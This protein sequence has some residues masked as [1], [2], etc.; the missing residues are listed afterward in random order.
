MPASFKMLNNVFLFTSLSLFSNSLYFIAKIV[1]LISNP[2]LI[3]A[4]V[5][6]SE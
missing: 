2:K 6:L 4:K 5:L 3:F 1:V